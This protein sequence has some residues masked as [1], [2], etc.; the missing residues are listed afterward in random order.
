MN[1]KEPVGIFRWLY[2]KFGED[3]LYNLFNREVFNSYVY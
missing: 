1:N 3:R 2:R